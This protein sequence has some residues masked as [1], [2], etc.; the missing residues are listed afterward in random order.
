MQKKSNDRF[1][2]QREQDRKLGIVAES[3]RDKKLMQSYFERKIHEKKE[4][5][6]LRLNTDRGMNF[7]MSKEIKYKDGALNISKDGLK[8]F[9]DDSYNTPKLSYHSIGIKKEKKK[10]SY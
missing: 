5:K 2:S 3:G 9:T 8:Q 10:L 7:H 1:Q 4:E 6:R